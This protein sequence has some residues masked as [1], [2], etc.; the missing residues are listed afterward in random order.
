MDRRAKWRTKNDNLYHG[1]DHRHL[2]RLLIEQGRADTI[3]KNRKR[4]PVN[5]YERA[6]VH[7]DGAGRFDERI[8]CAAR[9]R[10]DNLSA[11]P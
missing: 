9:P 7:D 10:N 4:I 1:I 6:Q 2:V 8:V 11:H 3:L 5:R